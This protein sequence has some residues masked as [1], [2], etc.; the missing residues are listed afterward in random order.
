MGLLQRRSSNSLSV[1]HKVSVYIDLSRRWRFLGLHYL[2]LY[3]V[4]QLI[5]GYLWI[6]LR[7][8]AR[9]LGLC[10]AD[11]R[12][13]FGTCCTYRCTLQMLQTQ[14]SPVVSDRPPDCR[15]AAKNANATKFWATICANRWCRHIRTSTITLRSD[16]SQY[17]F[18]HLIC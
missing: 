2:L 3:S 18:K 11:H 1:Q 17:H 6:M 5:Y 15:E 13:F 10:C 8:N 12:S 16:Q 9:Q 7:P 14:K 4:L